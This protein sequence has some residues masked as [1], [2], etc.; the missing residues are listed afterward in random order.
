[1]GLLGSCGRSR[2]SS[3]GGRA[4]RSSYEKA[5]GPD[6][7][8]PG[9]SVSAPFLLVLELLA[10]EFS[11]ASSRPVLREGQLDPPGAPGRPVPGLGEAVGNGPRRS[12]APGSDH[13]HRRSP[14]SMGSGTSLF[15][16]PGSVAVAFRYPFRPLCHALRRRARGSFMTRVRARIPLPVAAPGRGSSMRVGRGWQIPRWSSL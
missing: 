16:P 12:A 14:R 6:R 4:G 10:A 15:G 3:T 8:R 5:E 2:A 7:H 13:P 11:R 9:P 1:M